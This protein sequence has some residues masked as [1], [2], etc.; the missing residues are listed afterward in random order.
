MGTKRAIEMAEAVADG[1][2][3][4]ERAIGY[5]L[6]VNH[7]PP[8]PAEMIPVCIKAIETFNEEELFNTEIDLPEGITFRDRSTVAVGHVIDNFHLEPFLA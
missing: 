1:G 7:Y 2:I 5:H 3:D 4:L 6:T 8:V